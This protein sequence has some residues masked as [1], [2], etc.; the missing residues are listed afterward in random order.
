MLAIQLGPVTIEDPVILAPMSGVTDLPFRRLVKSFGAGLVVSEMIASA[1]MIR[2][3]RRSLVMAANAADEQPMSVQLAGCEPAVMEEAARLN[4]D[5][6]A[7]IIDINF[8][9]PVKKV[10]SGHAGSAL[11]RD[12][13]QAALAHQEKALGE[14]VKAH[15][16]I[17][18]GDDVEAAG[19]KLGPAIGE[20]ANSQ[21]RTLHV[22]EDA[23]LVDRVGGLVAPGALVQV[24]AAKFSPPGEEAR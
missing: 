2:E 11:M 6:G 3:T 16:G 9:C 23:E 19:D 5:R 17:L 4:A 13:L 22:G 8:G 7:A 14:I 1:A 15:A 21:L 10:V 18:E 20:I 12:E 24:G